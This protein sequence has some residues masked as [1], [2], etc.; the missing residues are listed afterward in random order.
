M[1]PSTDA[2]ERP[3]PLLRLLTL[4]AQRLNDRLHERL[5]AAGFAD[6][7]PGDDPAFAHIPP[8]GIRLTELAG[9]AGVTKQAMGEVVDSLAS[10]GY[11]ERRP[12]PTDG[13]A[14]VIAFAPRGWAAI[15]VA[16]DAFDEIERELAAT[17]GQRRIADLRRTLTAIVDGGT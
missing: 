1:E 4:A 9:R 11:V 13:R 8:E 6:Q 7:R 2:G 12:D 14:K 3:P 17:I 10:R 5:R 15:E 16:L